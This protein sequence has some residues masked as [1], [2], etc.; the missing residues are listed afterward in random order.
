MHVMVML[1]LA[2]E[3]APPKQPRAVE[4]GFDGMAMALHTYCDEDETLLRYRMALG[5]WLT[6][7]FPPVKG[8][9]H[10]RACTA[11]IAADRAVRVFAP[12]ALDAYGQKKLA[13]RLRAL[14]AITTR[15]LAE[16]ISATLAAMREAAEGQDYYQALDA[17]EKSADQAA[18]DFS[19][20][21]NE[22]RRRCT[23][24]EGLNEYQSAPID[25]A[26]AAVEAGASPRA[27][28]TAARKLFADLARAAKSR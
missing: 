27:V 21:F 20:A 26:L 19:Y 3:P 18:S 1:F 17:A 11:C 12:L 24:F 9:G 7:E 8:S 5:A 28:Q 2:A 10:T 13:A 16:K 22:D 4:E 23:D 15:V 6:E 25:A 14:P